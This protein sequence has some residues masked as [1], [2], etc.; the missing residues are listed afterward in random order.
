MRIIKVLAALAGFSVLAIAAYSVYA[1]SRV[2]E[3]L[4][5]IV[6]IEGAIGG[7]E[8]GASKEELFSKNDAEFNA[9]SKQPPCSTGWVAPA[10]AS[11]AQLTCLSA[12][13][14]WG[15]SSATLRQTCPLHSDKHADLFFA[16]NR[17]AKVRVWCTR[18]L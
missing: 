7:L 8:I 16:E 4:K 12:T 15:A 10:A 6:V 1:L 11:P 13:D 5:E 9:H 14:Q 18:P 3:T 17:L 2:G